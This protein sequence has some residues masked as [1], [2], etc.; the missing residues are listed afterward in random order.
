[1]DVATWAAEPEAAPE[2]T[3][4]VTDYGDCWGTQVGADPDCGCWSCGEVWEGL[5]WPLL[6]WQD[7]QGCPTCGGDCVLD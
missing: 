6:R 1:M 2:P 4:G 3:G 5:A 7:E